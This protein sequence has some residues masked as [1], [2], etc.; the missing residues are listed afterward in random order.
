MGIHKLV[1]FGLAAAIGVPVTFALTKLFAF[2][3][4]D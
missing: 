4:V 3:K 2:K 1:A